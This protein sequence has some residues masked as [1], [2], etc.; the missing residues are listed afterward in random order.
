MNN[1]TNIQ[2]R[3]AMYSR[4]GCFIATS[5]IMIVDLL[6]NKINPEHIAGF[7]VNHGHRYEMCVA[8]TLHN[9]RCI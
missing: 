4:G 2:E 6:T 9:E 5:R 1:E 7:L 8:A 3:E